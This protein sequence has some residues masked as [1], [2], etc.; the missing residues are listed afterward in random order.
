[1]THCG[2]SSIALGGVELD[3]APAIAVTP[4]P[5]DAR[6][7]VLTR[8]L[9]TGEEAS[10]RDF[11]AAYFDRLL[12]Y[13]LVVCRGDEDAARESLQRALVKI[14]R[15]VRRFDRADAWWG[16]LTVVARSCVVDG[17]RRQSRYR[18]VLE[19]YA[20]LFNPVAEPPQG[21]RL[22]D[23]LDE[24]LDAL[25]S[26][27]RAL[28]TAKY[29]RGQTTASLAAS[30][31]CTEKAMESRLARLRQRLKFQLLQRLRDEA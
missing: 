10:W 17:V 26:S 29:D 18:A 24:C 4:S 7:A 30:T 12:R 9:V 25:P 28:L 16:W 13:L 23:L 3:T 27:E 22:P 5:E 31:G 21:D 1:M 15:H 14:V 2:T 19:R 20:S 6:I 8:R 11:H